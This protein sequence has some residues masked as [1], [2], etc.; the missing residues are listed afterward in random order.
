VPKIVKLQS[1]SFN[2]PQF[3]ALVEATAKEVSG[4]EYTLEAICPF[5]FELTQD[6]QFLNRQLK[7]F[8]L[9]IGSAKAFD[10]PSDALAQEYFAHL[11]HNI[12]VVDSQFADRIV[13]FIIERDSHFKRLLKPDSYSPSSHD[14][15]FTIEHR[16]Y[17]GD[18]ITDY[19]D[20]LIATLFEF[21]NRSL[22]QL[23]RFDKSENIRRRVL[24]LP[25]SQLRH[26]HRR[27]LL[28]HR[29]AG[30]S[31]ERLSRAEWAAV[32]GRRQA[33]LAARCDRRGRARPIAAA[34]MP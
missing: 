1:D 8:F 11:L 3:R 22:P 2:L 28:V 21:G 26:R 34:S 13:V 15:V 9:Y 12:S 17:H 7:R 19:A 10:R 25:Q 33:A 23:N 32:R 27:L 4:A 29:Q 5:G 31:P 14:K 18:L 30:R 16:I 24:Q 20:F 6:P